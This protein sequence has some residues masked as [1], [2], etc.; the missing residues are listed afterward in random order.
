MPTL[1]IL[2]LLFVSSIF[3]LQDDPDSPTRTRVMEDERFQLD[4]DGRAED[5]QI[6]AGTPHL[7][8]SVLAI[9]PDRTTGEIE[10]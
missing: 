3:S 4:E 5:G 1:L 9:L 8:R 6:V 7:D 2:P 10:D